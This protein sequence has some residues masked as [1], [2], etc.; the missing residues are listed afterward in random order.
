MAQ[1][2]PDQI[3]RIYE[4]WKQSASRTAPMSA[5][6]QSRTWAAHLRTIAAY[7]AVRLGRWAG[8]P[9]LRRAAP[10]A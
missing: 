4:R 9:F 3:S 6:R 8:I 7:D 10:K 2:R 1:I 5:A